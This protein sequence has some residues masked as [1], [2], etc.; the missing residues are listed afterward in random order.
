MIEKMRE[1]SRGYFKY[2]LPLLS[3]QIQE[4]SGQNCA[5]VRWPLRS[6]LA[7]QPRHL[8]VPLLP[9]PPGGHVPG[10]LHRQRLCSHL[11]LRQLL[12]Q[13]LR[14]VLDE[15]ELQ[16]A[17]QKAAAV[18]QLSQAT[19]QPEQCEHKRDHGVRKAPFGLQFK[20]D[21]SVW[22]TL[23]KQRVVNPSNLL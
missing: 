2:D 23:P 14:P 16:Q 7:P 3:D 19:A 18:L 4:A 10:S 17:L 6:L 9:L 11:G 15:P 22:V 1:I 20:G 8:P 21:P 5:G 12:R 13:P